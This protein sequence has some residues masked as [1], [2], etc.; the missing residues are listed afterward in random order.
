MV[1]EIKK[2]YPD[3][4][5]IFITKKYGEP[6]EF[7]L[8]YWPWDPKSYQNDRNLK[9]DF[10]ADWYW[11]DSFDKFKFINDWEISSLTLPPKSL[12]VTS[13]NNSPA[14]LHLL[15]TINYPDNKPV[16]QFYTNEN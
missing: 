6:H 14:G 11:V 1:S 13:P 2:I 8:F 9:T 7:I 10:H 16:F 12:L 3:F 15:D 5:Q 4:D